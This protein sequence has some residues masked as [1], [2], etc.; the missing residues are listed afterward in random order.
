MT[1]GSRVETFASVTIPPLSGLN[2]TVSHGYLYNIP[3][4][5]R[6][7]V[8]HCL[9]DF[10]L[11]IQKPYCRLRFSGACFPFGFTQGD[12]RRSILKRT[13]YF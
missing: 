7:W 11:Y 12:L 13:N 5:K 2:F 6:Q 10:I 1:F 9:S 8:Y 3:K 4:K